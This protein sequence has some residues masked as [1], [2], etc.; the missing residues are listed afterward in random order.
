MTHIEKIV[1]TRTCIKCGETKEIPQR[2]KHACNIC[3][4]CQRAA[5]RQYQK[6]ETLKRGGTL[7]R[8]GRVPYPLNGEYETTNKKFR[9]LAIVTFKT[10]SREEWRE[11]M[12]NR[13]VNLSEDVLKWI[14]AHQEDETPKR[15]N[16]IK[17]DY[18]NTKGMTWEDYEK[19]LGDN[20]VDS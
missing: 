11:L 13:L 4:E 20:E 5:S 15:E 17:K 10:K 18:P 16:K 2:N 12:R 19:G 1:E 9:Q 3:V 8:T 7:G 14:Y 6:L